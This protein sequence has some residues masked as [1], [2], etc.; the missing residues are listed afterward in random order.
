MTSDTVDHLDAALDHLLAVR[1][2][3]GGLAEAPLAEEAM[4][5][6]L[7]ANASYQGARSGFVAALVHLRDAGVTDEA[8]F[9][10]EASAHEL[11]G[12]AAEVGWMLGLTARRG[13]T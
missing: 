11:A 1:V 4:E 6:A 9:A 10:V 5:V 3:L 7:G 13:S 2:A 8:I 12:R